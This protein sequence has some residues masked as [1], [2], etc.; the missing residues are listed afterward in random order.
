M[1]VQ[2]RINVFALCYMSPLAG[3]QIVITRA[4]RQSDELAERLHRLGAHPLLHPAISIAPPTNMAPLDTAVAALAS[5]QWLIFTSANGV[6]ATFERMTLADIAPAA[7]H[8]LSVAA[9]GPATTVALAEYGLQPTLVPAQHSAEGLLAAFGNLAGQRVLLP[10]ADIARDT[11]AAGLRASG[12]LVDVVT[13]YR[14]VPGPGGRTLLPLLH[15]R[16]VDAVTFTSSSTVRFLLDGMCSTGISRAVAG[17]LLQT[18]ALV[19]IGPATAITARTEG[20][21]V[22]ATAETYTTD[23]II[24]ALVR[25]FAN[26]EA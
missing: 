8:R 2:E 15:E 21:G 22:T 19:C 16:A 9:V 7:L 25:V 18:A 3:K 10:I 17:T 1:R 12:A 14:T 20:L 11:L 6:R 4:E 23:G 26:G 13:A 24:K 5:Y